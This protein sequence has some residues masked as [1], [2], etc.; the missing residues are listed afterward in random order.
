MHLGLEDGQEPLRSFDGTM[1]RILLS[2]LSQDRGI[3]PPLSKKEY[4]DKV[5]NTWHLGNFV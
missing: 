2:C 5:K 3:A 1:P 4:L